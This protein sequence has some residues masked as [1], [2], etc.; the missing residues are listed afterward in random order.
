VAEVLDKLAKI[1]AAFAKSYA[2]MLDG[3]L[4]RKLPAAVCTI[5]EAHY[6]NPTT[7][8]IAAV[9]LSLFNDVITRAAFTRGLPVIDLRLIIDADSDYANDIEPSV[10]GGA[11]IARVVATLVTTHD[12]TRRRSEVYV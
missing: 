3:V 6:P 5:Y 8:K 7:R 12:F 11:K 4:A 1:K 2:A 10:T 9:G